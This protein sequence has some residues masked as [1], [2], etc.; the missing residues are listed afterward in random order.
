M[1]TTE[2][3]M[4]VFPDRLKD[5]DY[6]SVNGDRGWFQMLKNGVLSFL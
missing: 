1:D 5:G 6:I 2:I 3:Y 4:L